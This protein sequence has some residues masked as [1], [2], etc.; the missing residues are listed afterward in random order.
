MDD[1][2]RMKML[3]ESIVNATKN[4]DD[5]A[6]SIKDRTETLKKGNWLFDPNAITSS[7]K[8]RVENNTLSFSDPKS[9]VYALPNIGSSFSELTMM[10][11]QIATSIIAK[12]AA[13]ALAP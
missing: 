10:G 13:R 6:E 4:Y 9:W 12:Q 11:G 3:E 2:T 7:F 1:T 8:E 5:K